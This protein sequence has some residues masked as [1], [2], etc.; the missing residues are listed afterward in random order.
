MIFNFFLS[1]DV[2][3]GDERISYRRCYTRHTTLLACVR[4][5]HVLH[6][7]TLKFV[8]FFVTCLR[9]LF[10]NKIDFIIVNCTIRGTHTHTQ[11]TL[12]CKAERHD[13]HFKMGIMEV[14]VPWHFIT[15]I[16]HLNRF[17]SN[18]FVGA[19]SWATLYLQ[20]LTRQLF[21]SSNQLQLNIHVLS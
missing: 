9:W 13:C 18:L 1:G 8:L 16:F 7:H 5:F 17:F 19:S 12:T 14:L 10:Q 15:F 20:F 6:E 2:N 4:V 3:S 21:L 11:R